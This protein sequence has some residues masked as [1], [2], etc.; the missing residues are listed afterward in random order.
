MTLSPW[1]HT[2]FIWYTLLF[3]FELYIGWVAQG[4]ID[5]NGELRVIFPDRRIIPIFLLSNNEDEAGIKLILAL[6]SAIRVCVN[7][8]INSY[9]SICI[10]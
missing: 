7:K 4:R 10:I 1:N 3:V 8:T 5:N 2:R 9:S 6:F